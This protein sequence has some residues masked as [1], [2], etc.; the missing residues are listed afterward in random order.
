[1]SWCRSLCPCQ[2]CK[3]NP[4]VAIQQWLTH[5][6]KAKNSNRALS[7]HAPAAQDSLLSFRTSGFTHPPE[8][9][10]E[11]PP[12]LCPCT[13]PRL[14][15]P[16]GLSLISVREK[17]AG[18]ASSGKKW[19]TPCQM[20]FQNSGWPLCNAHHT[21]HYRW[22]LF[23]NLNRGSTFHLQKWEFKDF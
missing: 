13:W 11:Y 3:P 21:W 22:R 12:C 9:C 10:L 20:A 15:Y 2:L 5:T 17:R 1:M 19:S 4:N 8:L 16:L 14:T 18:K 6:I 7:L 23:R